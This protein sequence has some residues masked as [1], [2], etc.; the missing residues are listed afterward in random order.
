[1]HDITL[2]NPE[3][4][5][6]VLGSILLDDDAIDK[7]AAFLKPSAFSA[8][9][10][11]NVYDVMLRLHGSGKAIDEV[12]IVG[13]FRNL[14]WISDGDGDDTDP[15]A[16]QLKAVLAG[17]KSSVPTAANVKHYA[18][19]VDECAIQRNLVEVGA[20][21][22]RLP[23]DESGLNVEEMVD[24]AESILFSISQHHLTGSLIHIKKL[25]AESYEYYER[26][27]VNDDVQLGLPC[28][29]TDLDRLIG[30]FDPG[31][32]IILAGRPSMGKS[33]LAIGMAENM[34]ITFNARVALFSMEM[35]ARQIVQRM[36][37]GQTGI[38]SQRLRVG[39]LDDGSMDRISHAI[40]VLGGA[41]IF[42]DETPALTPMQLRSKARR[43]DSEYG[44]DVIFVDYLQLMSGGTRYVNRVEEI[45]F[46]SRSL[47]ALARELQ[48]PVIALSQ[49]SRKVESREG[50]R[51]MLSDLRGSGTIEQDADVVMFLYRD[52]YYNKDTDRPNV[53]ELD[54]AKYRNGPTGT[55]EFRFIR[56]LA[57]FANLNAIYDAGMNNG[58]GD[59]EEIPW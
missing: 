47:K 50:K 55:V 28:G 17:A 52:E 44:L 59:P 46:I 34:G 29:Y 21:I 43:A 49:L 31:D 57:K 41:R 56:E 9:L 24:R 14:D 38:D 30:G 45:S 15:T 26:L 32:L 35:G 58:N 51:P 6:G 12:T 13:E 11:R 40:E 33:A 23:Y 42:I 54:V 4:E 20:Q 25:L 27:H 5:Q 16:D 19:T 22:A 8:G 53:A 1:M 2:A 7:V 39:P 3:A 18:R 36:V 10:R 37:S 48:L